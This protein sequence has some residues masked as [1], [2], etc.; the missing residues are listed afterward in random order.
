[1][2]FVYVAGLL[3][4]RLLGPE[5]YGLYQLVFLVPGLLAPFL[6]FGIEITLVRFVAK[7]LVGEREKGI[8]TAR[9]LFF[10]RLLI[11]SLACLSMFALAPWIAKALGEPVTLGMRIAGLF[12]LGNML[13]LFIHAIFQSFFMMR[14]RTIIMA[15]HGAVYLVTV[16]IL[17]YID[18]AYLAPIA[19][20]ALATFAAFLVGLLL[21]WRKGVKLL[22]SPSR[23]GIPMLEQLKFAAPVYATLLLAAF[24]AQAGV[25]LIR[26]AGLAV[27]HVGLFRAVY[28]IVALGSFI[29]IT[30]NV[31]V[32]PYVSELESKKDL[33][34]LR[35]F[36]SLIIKFLM[37][38][39][40]PA[41]IGFFLL[42]K[43][44]LEALLPDYLEALV[45]MRILSLMLLFLPVFLVSNMMLM[46]LGRP[47]LVMFANLIAAV[48]L[49]AAGVLLAILAGTEGI[50]FA[51]LI[52]MFAGT[53]YSLFMLS[54][55]VGLELDFPSIGK[56][57]VST[58]IMGAGVHLVMESIPSP[59]LQI[60]GALPVGLAVY[61]VLVFVLR[62]MSEEDFGVIKRTI[63]IAR[64]IRARRRDQT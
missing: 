23:A 1:M 24:F 3:V 40:I 61:L 13:Y 20:F 30:L 45:I 7:Y 46:G 60:V 44:V 58:A 56:V 48:C 15:V 38:I 10:I 43:P 27:V 37:L 22:A 16:P 50:A 32:F 42:A 59:I 52:S 25:I 26:L 9:F 57:A 5:D 8:R 41:S 34:T 21:A 63:G 2:A 17:I 49:A 4:M 12:L 64:E 18:M 14:E 51:Y 36:C 19:A 53:A 35:Y 39:G 62:A 33:D 47:K 6:S 28:N 54:R 29:A 11:S 31:V 55:V